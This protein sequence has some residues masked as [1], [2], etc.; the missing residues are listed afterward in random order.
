MVNSVA[1]VSYKNL[2]ENTLQ[3]NKWSRNAKMTSVKMAKQLARN[4][5]SANV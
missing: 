2:G 4:V 3:I 5:V 1:P